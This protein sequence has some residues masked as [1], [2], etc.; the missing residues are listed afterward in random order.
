MRKHWQSLSCCILLILVS[1]SAST[2]DHMCKYVA[3]TRKDIGY[4]YCIKFFQA[5]KASATANNRG[6]GV[7]TKISRAA[8]SDTLKRIDTHMASDKDK[9]IH[10]RLSDKGY[11]FLFKVA[12]NLNAV[13]LDTYTCENGFRVLGVNSPL[14]AEDAKFLKD[15]SI[16]LIITVLWDLHDICT[17]HILNSP[18]QSR[19]H[20]C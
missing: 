14:A 16:S 4:N 20:R 13:A 1:S 2:L 8:A 9:K 17:T 12:V 19:Q 6:L 11:I 3:T 15:C 5:D 7:A 18:P 10:A